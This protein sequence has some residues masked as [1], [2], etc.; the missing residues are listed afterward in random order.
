MTSCMV[1]PAFVRRVRVSGPF[2]RTC[3][4]GLRTSVI[5][6]KTTP[7]NEKMN[8]CVMMRKAQYRARTVLSTW[9]R[10]RSPC[11]EVSDRMMIGRTSWRMAERRGGAIPTKAEKVHW[12]L[13][14]Q[15]SRK[16]TYCV[17]AWKHKRVSLR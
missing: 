10:V 12:L 14:L 9:L 6:L 2:Q 5:K 7:S 3:W 16:P 8:S 1:I 15:R 4:R 17:M 11:L 13:L